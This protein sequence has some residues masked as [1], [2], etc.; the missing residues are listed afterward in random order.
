MRSK[1]RKYCWGAIANVSVEDVS[2]SDSIV[3][4][5]LGLFD[6]DMIIIDIGDVEK[7]SQLFNAVKDHNIKCK[8]WQTKEEQYVDVT[9]MIN[10]SDVEMLIHYIFSSDVESFAVTEVNDESLWESYLCYRNNSYKLIKCNGIEFKI[11]FEMF[12]AIIDIIFPK[13]IYDFKEILLKLKKLLI[14]A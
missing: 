12:E 14:D 13:D 4:N 10:R 3:L 6:Y 7:D 9:L 11:V 8:I 2:I 1:I 5:I